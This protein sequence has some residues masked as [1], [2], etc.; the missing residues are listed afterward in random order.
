MIRRNSTPTWQQHLGI[1]IIA[2]F[3]VTCG[4]F[5]F[6]LNSQYIGR[7]IRVGPAQ[8]VGWIVTLVIIMLA[9]IA[10][11]SLLGSYLLIKPEQKWKRQIVIGLIFFVI[12]LPDM[13]LMLISPA[14]L[15]V[16]ESGITG[17]IP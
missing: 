5:L 3:P 4:A 8:P 17:P 11:F 12:L 15:L 6:V 2:T 1:L 7:L 10:Y 14:F 16:M 13:I 9:G